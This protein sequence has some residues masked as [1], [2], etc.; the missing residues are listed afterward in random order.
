M[1]VSKQLNNLS[2]DINKSK[3]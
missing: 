3:R 1:Q 2:Y